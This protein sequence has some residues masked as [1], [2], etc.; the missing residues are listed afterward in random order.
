MKKPNSTT[1]AVTMP[2]ATHGRSS[3]GSPEP[4]LGSAAKTRASS[5]RCT[6]GVV[7]CGNDLDGVGPQHADDHD[8]RSRG[9]F[10]VGGHRLIFHG[11]VLQVQVDLAGALPAA[12]DVQVDGAGAADGAA[13]ADGPLG[14]E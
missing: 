13:D 3:S 2:I 8:L 6:P 1:A 12:G 4:L 7:G 14:A 10:A 5:M 11:P 9:Q